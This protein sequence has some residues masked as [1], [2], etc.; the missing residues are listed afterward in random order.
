MSEVD[1]APLSTASARLV[2]AA[3]ARVVRVTAGRRELSGLV[4]ADDQIVTAEECIA[5]DEGV[6]VVLADGRSLSRSR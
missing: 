3:A 6:A 1:L 4:W 5:D 2:E